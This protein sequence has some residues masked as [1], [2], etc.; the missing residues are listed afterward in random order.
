[1]LKSCEVF[2]QNEKVQVFPLK[3]IGYFQHL[4][5][6]NLSFNMIAWES[7]ENLCLIKDSLE[8]LDLTGNDLQEIPVRLK[9]LCNLKTLNLSNN[10]LANELDKPERVLTTLADLP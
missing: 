4:R 6:L 8:S 2:P 10:L 7:L 5:V 1:M 3:D 9:D